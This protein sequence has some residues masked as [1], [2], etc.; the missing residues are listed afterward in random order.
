MRTAR[1]SVSILKLP[2]VAK[3]SLTL[4]VMRAIRTPFVQISPCAT[5]GA[6]H[7]RRIPA[8]LT[9]DG[10]SRTH[11]ATYAFK[12]EG[13]TVQIRPEASKTSARV[14]ASK[15]KKRK[16]RR[17][18]RSRHG[19]EAQDHGNADFVG[20]ARHIALRPSRYRPARMS[21]AAASGGTKRDRSRL[22]TTNSWHEGAHHRIQT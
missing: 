21:R 20:Y 11:H 4:L 8:T 14:K 2:V 17:A 9:N 10:P 19:N 1:T 7:R 18:S 5:K 3:P 16:D 12:S 15:R 13:T 22:R 6:G